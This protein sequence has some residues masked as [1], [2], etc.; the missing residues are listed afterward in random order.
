MFLHNVHHNDVKMTLMVSQLSVYT[1]GTQINSIL[2]YVQTRFFI[3]THK[4]NHSIYI[5]VTLLLKFH[6]FIYQFFFFTHW[7][8]FEYKI[9]KNSYDFMKTPCIIHHVFHTAS[10]F[11][12]KKYYAFFCVNR[13]FYGTR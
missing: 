1:Q 7:T 11:F 2:S 3:R 10:V 5:V 13:K 8:Q 9:R 12:L 4:Y 6:L